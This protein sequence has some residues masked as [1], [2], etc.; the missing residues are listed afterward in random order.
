MTLPGSVESQHLLQVFTDHNARQLTAFEDPGD[1]PGMVD[2][3]DGVS[4][5]HVLLGGVGLVDQNVVRP[6]ERAALR[7][8]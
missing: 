1:V 8:K 3:P 4:H 2:Q 6:L 7:G 5:A